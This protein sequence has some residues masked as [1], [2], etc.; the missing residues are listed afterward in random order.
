MAKKA[1][2]HFLP[3]VPLP[4]IPTFGTGEVAE[5]LGAPMWRLQKFLLSPKYRLAAGQ[6]GEGRGSRRVFSTEDIY[7]IA[8]AGRMVDD[9]FAAPFVGLVLGQIDNNDFYPSHDSE[10]NEVSSRLGLFGIRR[11][12]KRRPQLV[13]TFDPQT[14]GQQGAPYYVLDA[15]ELIAEVDKRIAEQLR[16]RLRR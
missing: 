15:G 5:I 14:L 8:I 6:I 4:E 10:G 16:A 9:G 13:F 12:A 7:R 1:I 3:G 11:S 2:A